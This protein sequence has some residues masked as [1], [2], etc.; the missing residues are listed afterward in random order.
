MI[1]TMYGED[2]GANMIAMFVRL[3]KYHLPICRT[4]FLIKVSV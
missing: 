2:K 1:A 4:Q 3:S